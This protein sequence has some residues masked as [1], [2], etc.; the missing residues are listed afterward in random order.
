MKQKNIA[1]Y[2]MPLSLVFLLTA[3]GGGGGVEHYDPP[4]EIRPVTKPAPVS[5]GG[6]EPSTPVNT[7]KPAPVSIEELAPVDVPKPQDEPEPEAE[8]TPPVTP[9]NEEQTAPLP[10]ANKAKAQAGHFLTPNF[11]YNEFTSSIVRLHHST[12]DGETE[13]RVE[14]KVKKGGTGDIYFAGLRHV[15]YS[16]DGKLSAILTGASKPFAL[17]SHKLGEKL[18][19]VTTYRP[20]I[21]GQDGLDGGL[22][23]GGQ[24]AGVYTSNAS[25]A[26]FF[27]DPAVADWNYQTY[28]S[29][30]ATGNIEADAVYQ[31]IGDQTP[32]ASLPTQGQGE[33]KGISSGTKHRSNG[34]DLITADVTVKADFGKRELEFKTDNTKVYQFDKNEGT[35]K[36]DLDLS[37][38]A[39]WHSAS[40]NFK[41]EIKTAD[42]K[43][44]G[45]VDGRFYGPNADE[46][47]GVFGVSNSD[48][49]ENYLG[50]FGA[51]RE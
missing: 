39:K 27:R 7:P 12:V 40:N 8:S 43:M 34:T 26:Y 31:S 28:G 16:E 49:S 41:G 24:Y 37:G 23:A 46:I 6:N 10:A 17:F 48:K 33:Y 21:D 19:H 18:E 32:V 42:Q 30:K 38:T 45:Q 22:K 1:L 9:I 29:F 44:T 20:G 2:A 14:F 5:T 13:N 15:T 25:P 36:A 47:G 50:G 11:T 35:E 3:C 4:V 51:R